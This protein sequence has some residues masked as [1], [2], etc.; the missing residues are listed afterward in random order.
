MN[1]K[2]FVVFLLIVVLLS[3]AHHV[4]GHDENA[5]KYVIFRDDD[6]QPGYK[7]NTLKTVNK[8][9]V[10]KNVPVT[11][12]IIPHPYL[13]RVGNE[14]YMD[15]AFF[16][17]MNS[18]SSNPLFEFAQH[19]YTHKDVTGTLNKSEFYGVPYSSQYNSIKQGQSDISKAFGIK[20]STFM[21]PF[22]RS[23]GNTLKAL[24]ALGF[25]EYSTAF[26]DFNV[27]Q[28]YK[29]GVRMDS[30]SLILDDATLQS[31]KNETERLF[32]EE[33]GSDTII[34][35]YHFATF[36]G[37]GEVLN[38]TKVQLLESYI[39]YLKQRGDVTFTKLD[40]SYLAEG[41]T[42]EKQNTNSTSHANSTVT[43]SNVVGYKEISENGDPF[44]I[45]NQK[46][47]PLLA[48]A[49]PA[50]AIVFLGGLLTFNRL[51][52]KKAKRKR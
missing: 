44:G 40:R 32:T 16:E 2:A 6:V 19:G 43:H 14:L 41:I 11:L 15:Q 8:I 3:A 12:G 18:I 26:R 52:N 9:H 33:H 39:D 28:G 20:P 1:G 38:E 4:S 10:D 47:W 21:P 35:L 25:T 5:K 22:D 50:Y 48:F 27:N 36:S 7:V 13:N 34:V 45:G 23:D 30:V 51:S 46:M 37:P 42:S 24:R 31:A 49:L 29:E 17:Y